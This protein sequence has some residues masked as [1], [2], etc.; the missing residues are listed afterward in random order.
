MISKRVSPYLTP[1]KITERSLYFSPLFSREKA[2]TE[3]LSQV[4]KAYGPHLLVGAANSL[5]VITI[6]IWKT[7]YTISSTRE[8]NFIIVFGNMIWVCFYIPRICIL[9]G[10]CEST[11]AEGKSTADALQELGMREDHSC[12]TK[13][14]V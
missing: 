12:A 7:F 13:D 5:A 1:I 3:T 14:E 8:I 2:L 11:V 9:A 4:N 10:A 6:E